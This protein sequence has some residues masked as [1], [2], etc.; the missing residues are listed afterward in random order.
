MHK[1]IQP[2]SEAQLNLP[3]C[4]FT[5]LKSTRHSSW[6]GDISEHLNSPSGYLVVMPG[7][8]LVLLGCLSPPDATSLLSAIED[9]PIQYISPV[10]QCTNTMQKPFCL[11]CYLYNTMQNI[12]YRVVPWKRTEQFCECLS[13]Q[14][15]IFVL[16]TVSQCS[17]PGIAT[18]YT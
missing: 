6:H 1:C 15:C 4:P 18:V 7:T 12:V 13:A 3:H 14:Y 11:V 16:C 10:H 2:F 17:T 5:V 8:P 9:V